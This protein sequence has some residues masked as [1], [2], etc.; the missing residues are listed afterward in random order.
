[1]ETDG[2]AV[3]A[4]GNTVETDGT[5]GRLLVVV[6]VVVLVGVLV[7]TGAVY[8]KVAV[9]SIGTE[10]SSS[11]IDKKLVIARFL[12]RVTWQLCFL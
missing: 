10:L 3:D 7:I 6:R 8:P 5:T 4:G 12:F 11:S 9:L 2:T 1:M